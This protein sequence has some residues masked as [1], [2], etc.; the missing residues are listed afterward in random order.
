MQSFIR[1]LTGVPCR[2][3]QITTRSNAPASLTISKLQWG[4][5]NPH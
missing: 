5:A 2:I 4:N 1:D 3:Y